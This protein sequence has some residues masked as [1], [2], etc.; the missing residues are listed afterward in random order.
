MDLRRHDYRRAVY[1]RFRGLIGAPDRKPSLPSSGMDTQASVVRVDPGRAG[2]RVIAAALVLGSILAIHA[3]WTGR[4]TSTTSLSISGGVPVGTSASSPASAPSADTGSPVG[5][6]ASSSSV[7]PTVVVYVVGPVRH[8][9]VFSLP[10]GSRAIDALHAAGGIRPGRRMGPVNLA[11]LLVDGSR[12]DFGTGVGTAP[13][14]S[15]GSSATTGSST[16]PASSGPIDLNQ[17]TLTDLDALPGVGPILAQRILE[18]RSAHGRFTSVD[19]LREV[20]GIG[21]RKFESLRSHVR[22]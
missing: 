22:V 14:S 17:A 1:E 7:S 2:S 21:A 10:S 6:V 11:A 13:G 5:G 9:G 15:V 12:L 20:S 18:W 19:E 8:P 4:A 3:F 16:D